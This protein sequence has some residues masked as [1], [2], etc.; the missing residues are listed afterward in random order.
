M[1]KAL[2][3]RV[4]CPV[5]TFGERV[6]KQGGEVSESDVP[7]GQLDWLVDNQ[8]LAMIEDEEPVKTP[9]APAITNDGK[10]K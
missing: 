3:F 9:A 1:A 8:K 7:K 5:L 10:A 4:I 2:K 6:F